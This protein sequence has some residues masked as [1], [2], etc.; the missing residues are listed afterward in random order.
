MVNELHSPALDTFIQSW[1]TEII[2]CLREDPFNIL[3]KCYPI[4]AA[5][6]AANFP[7]LDI[8]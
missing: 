6:V 4:V 5:S 2:T 8:V 3:H 1:R 7:Q